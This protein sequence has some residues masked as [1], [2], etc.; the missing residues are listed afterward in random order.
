MSIVAAFGPVVLTLAFAGPPTPEPHREDSYPSDAQVIRYLEGKRI[1]VEAD[2]ARAKQGKQK[3][4]D[5]ERWN[6]RNRGR[7]RWLEIQR[8]GFPCI[9][10]GTLG[11]E[12][13]L[14]G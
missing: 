10:Q 2:P 6:R 8:V 7:G 4:A 3:S 13:H 1:T 9:G 5:P 11:D 14:H 12:R